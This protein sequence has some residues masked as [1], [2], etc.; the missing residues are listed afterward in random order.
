MEE[1]LAGVP[2]IIPKTAISDSVRGLRGGSWA[3]VDGLESWDDI[4]IFPALELNINGFRVASVPEPSSIGL[5]WVTA[6]GWLVWKRRK[7]AHPPLLI[8]L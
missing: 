8:L 3:G 7:A 1:H 2:A 4:N 5:V 6:S